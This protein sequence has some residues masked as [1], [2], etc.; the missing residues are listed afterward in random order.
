MEKAR[1]EE[2]EEIDPERWLASHP[3]RAKISAL[4][5]KEA[6]KMAKK[7][8][9]RKKEVEKKAAAKV[10]TQARKEE[11]KQ[12]KTLEEVKESVKAAKE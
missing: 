6:N 12:L 10:K 5:N 7:D 2:K 9:S 11:V 3:D 1:K 8:A 4:V